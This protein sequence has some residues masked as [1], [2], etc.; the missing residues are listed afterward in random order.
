MST[1]KQYKPKIVEQAILGFL[2]VWQ[3][4]TAWVPCPAMAD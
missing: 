1:E 3:P 2:N 4:L